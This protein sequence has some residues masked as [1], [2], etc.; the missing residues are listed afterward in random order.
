M[1][2]WTA[3]NRFRSGPGKFGDKT[4][5][6]IKG[7][8][9]WGTA[10]KDAFAG[11]MASGAK[12]LGLLVRIEEYEVGLAKGELPGTVKKY[13]SIEDAA[14]AAEQRA[15]EFKKA[16]PD[17]A[18]LRAEYQKGELASLDKQ[19]SLSDR[20]KFAYQDLVTLTE[21][22]NHLDETAIDFKT[23]DY[24]LAIE[25]QK[26]S[27]DILDLEKEQARAAQEKAD[28]DKE[29]AAEKEREHQREMQRLEE[30]KAKRAEVEGEISEIQSKAAQKKADESKLTI[31]ELANLDVFGAGV[32]IEAGE[33]GE[34]ARN[35]LALRD[36]AEA[37]R[38]QGDVASYRDL[39]GQAQAEADQLHAPG[40]LLKSTEMPSDQALI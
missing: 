3:S 14:N 20:I 22:R 18:R 13:A 6:N 2:L 7:A 27:N 34:K 40:N 26:Q 11:M 38:K 19:L 31:G 15:A 29:I 36:Q 4:N 39:I 10:F 16:N 32:S 23:K 24:Q 25:I 1:S 33:Q 21:K 28:K 30:L 35:I 17:L 37:A 8:I 12:A 5:E 9:R